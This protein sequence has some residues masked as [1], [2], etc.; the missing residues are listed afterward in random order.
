MK[1]I[2][3]ECRDRGFR[4]ACHHTIV[5]ASHVN[6]IDSCRMGLT[7]MEHFLGLAEALSTSSSIQNY[8]PDYNYDNELMRALQDAH[9]W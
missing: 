4:S 5:W 9:M 1:A 2:Y 8:L 6:A 3:D 7:S